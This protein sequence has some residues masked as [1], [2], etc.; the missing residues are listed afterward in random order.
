MLDLQGL[1]SPATTGQVQSGL[2]N[3]FAFIDSRLMD[4]VGNRAYSYQDKRSLIVELREYVMD[5]SRRGLIPAQLRQ[6]WLVGLARAELAAI[7]SQK[8][9]R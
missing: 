1:R 7:E 5:A 8:R 2:M 3:A 6:Q 4:V 9:Q